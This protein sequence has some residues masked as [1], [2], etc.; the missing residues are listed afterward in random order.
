MTNEQKIREA[1]AKEVWA[2]TVW[3][4]CGPTAL[5]IYTAGYLALL[6]ELVISGSIICGDKFAK[7]GVKY[8]LYEGV[9]DENKY[10]EN[11]GYELIP[12]YRLPEGVNR[13]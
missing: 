5:D 12:I 13:D 1:F 8:D 10:W 6:N 2:D 11:R 7:H 9:Y 4:G 3:E